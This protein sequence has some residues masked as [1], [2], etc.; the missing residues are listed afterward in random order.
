MAGPERAATVAAL[1][2]LIPAPQTV[3]PGAYVEAA[4]RRATPATK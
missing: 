3:A 2:S 1:I 4:P